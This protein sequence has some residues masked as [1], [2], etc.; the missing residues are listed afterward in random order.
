MKYGIQKIL[1]QVG[2][3]EETC[4]LKKDFSCSRSE[5]LIK[6]GKSWIEHFF[7]NWDNQ[8]TGIYCIVGR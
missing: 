6:T 1:L 2:L 8:L 7:R 3:Q 4:Y 5:R